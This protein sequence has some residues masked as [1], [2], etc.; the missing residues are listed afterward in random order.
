[1][2]EFCVPSSFGDSTGE[3]SGVEVSNSC[4]SVLSPN[5]E[6]GLFK[7]EGCEDF[8]PVDDGFGVGVGDFCV[9]VLVVW[10]EEVCVGAG[11]DDDSTGQEPFPLP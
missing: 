9:E 6:L 7:G 5:T 1:M 11:E 10:V 2:D 8:A 4:S 3:D